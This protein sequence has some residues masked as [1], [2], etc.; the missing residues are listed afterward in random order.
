MPLSQVFKNS[1]MQYAECRLHTEH[2]HFLSQFLQFSG[3]QFCNKLLCH[4]VECNIPTY[5]RI[6]KTDLSGLG[7]E[8]WFVVARYAFAKMNL[9]GQGEII[10]AKT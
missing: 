8:P 7:A 2:T 1:G 10:L 5:I 3:L 9:Q 4:Y 6:G